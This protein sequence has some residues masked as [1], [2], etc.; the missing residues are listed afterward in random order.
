MN[1]RK[2][3]KWKRTAKILV[4]CGSMLYLTSGMKGLENGIVQGQSLDATEDVLI[5]SS[6]ERRED[7]GKTTSEVPDEMEAHSAE[8]SRDWSA[9]ESY[10]LAKIAMA[11]AEGEDVEGKAL[12]IMVVLNRVWSDNFPDTIEE[13]IM[14]E[15]NGVHQFS[16]TQ[17]GGRWWTTEPDK[18]CYE[19][20]E[21]IMKE[22]WDE[23]QGA[24]YFESKGESTWHRD[25]L[26][27]LFQHGNHYFYKE[28]GE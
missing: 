14:Q 9:E 16:V 27:F 11:E 19:A 4:V 24:V 18:M 12:V 6:E 26:E 15:T 13:V 5:I 10:L 1:P 28:K 7:E 2:R 25:H 3:K 21:M 23:S 17:E 22:Q 8:R 20:L